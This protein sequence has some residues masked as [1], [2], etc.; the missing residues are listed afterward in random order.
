VDANGNSIPDVAFAWSSTAAA[1][2]TVDPATGLATA[3]GNGETAIMA[4][5][6]GITGT[7]ALTVRQ[8]VVAVKVSP[9]PATL[10][11]LGATLQFAAE[12][13]DANGHVV[14][15]AVFAWHS[16]NP[17][18]AT[19]DPASGLATAVANGSVTI[20]AAADGAVGA[21][22]LT[23]TQLVASVEVMPA[24]ATLT[25]LGATRQ[26]TAEARDANGHVIAGTAF[27]WTSS[28]VGV[29]TV[30]PRTGLATAIAN[31]TATIRAAAASVAGEAR[32]KVCA[33]TGAPGASGASAS[34]AVPGC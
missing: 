21:A 25:V 30:D 14:A 5:A 27:A 13:R 20:T 1:V 2:A 6:D 11:A 22:E 28:D 26:F 24:E 17:A 29:A 9:W 34:S 31:G 12:G 3:I 15:D 7:A 4:T 19:V 8:V 18:V 16:T 33:L 10:S 23:V 32:L